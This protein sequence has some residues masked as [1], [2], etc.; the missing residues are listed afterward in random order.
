LGIAALFN[1]LRRRVQSFID[2][3]FFRSMYIAEKVLEQFAA[4]TRHAV[5]LEHLTDVLMDV[6]EQTVQPVN[7]GLWLKPK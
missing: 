2:R 3:R 6:V 4:N 7:M 5:E 1:P